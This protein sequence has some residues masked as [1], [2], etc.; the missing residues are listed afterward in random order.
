MLQYEYNPSLFIAPPERF[1]SPAATVWYVKL[2]Q[3]PVSYHALFIYFFIPF[4][5][6]VTIWSRISYPS[7]FRGT[8]GIMFSCSFIVVAE[9]AKN[10]VG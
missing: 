1:S 5:L 7:D 3:I 6:H 8:K 2:L 4:N 10:L 9:C